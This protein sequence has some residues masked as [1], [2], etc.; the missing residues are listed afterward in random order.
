M[1]QKLEGKKKNKLVVNII[2]SNS[3]VLE[4]PE[5]GYE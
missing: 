4:Y 3:I 5:G 1:L 2:L